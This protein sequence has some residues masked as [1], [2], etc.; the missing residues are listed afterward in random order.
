[1]GGENITTTVEGRE[2]YPVNVRYL[3]DFRSGLDKLN[4]VLVATP[5]GA[6]VPTLWQS[7][8]RRIRPP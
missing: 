3:R 5:S 7:G 8:P 2:R 1:V 4:R 6:Q